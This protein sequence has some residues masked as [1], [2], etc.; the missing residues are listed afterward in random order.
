MSNIF[1]D[2]PFSGAIGWA[3][4]VYILFV[5][6]L[7]WVGGRHNGAPGVLVRTAAAL[8]VLGLLCAMVVLQCEVGY[9]VHGAMVLYALL[10]LAAIA[11]IV[12]VISGA[13]AYLQWR[14]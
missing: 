8:L 3:T 14:K 10:G 7:P 13:P 1:S 9:C 5:A 2:T 6:V 11:A 4:L 12:T